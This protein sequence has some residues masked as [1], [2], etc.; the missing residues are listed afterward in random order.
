MN[1][2]ERR[3]FLVAP[4]EQLKS[5]VVVSFRCSPTKDYKPLEAV[6][7]TNQNL[8]E[9]L[10][11]Q[12]TSTGSN[13][14]VERVLATSLNESAGSGQ[15]LIHDTTNGSSEI[16]IEEIELSDKDNTFTEDDD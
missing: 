4:I 16:P 2:R 14:G 8:P 5:V 3:I 10:P 11:V 6:S 15:L 9:N 1:G 13:E 7:T 12:V